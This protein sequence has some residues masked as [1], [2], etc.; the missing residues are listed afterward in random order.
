VDPLA[1]M[2]F[3]YSQ[4]NYTGNNPTN[5]IDP[6]GRWVPGLDDKGNV[7]L[8]A[9]KSDNFMTLV[10][11]YGGDWEMANSVWWSIDSGEEGVTEG[12]SIGGL[13]VNLTK[14]VG[15]IYSEIT[16]AFNAPLSSAL[17]NEDFNCF[18]TS[19]DILRTGEINIEGAIKEGLVGKSNSSQTADALLE[20]NAVPLDDE[21]DAVVG[22]T[23][24]RYQRAG[25]SVPSH[26]ATYMGKDS[27]NNTYVLTK[28]GSFRLDIQKS[29]DFHV[30]SQNWPYGNK[31][32][33]LNGYG[34]IK[35][36]KKD[37]T[38]YYKRK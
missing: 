37:I 31:R 23:L 26:F 11:Y 28:N 36:M 21:N 13:S 7:T 19:L 4:Y 10:D 9:E 29:G 33:D 5:F 34:T 8:T 3:S 22:Q 2:Y 24:I 25:E 18:S 38:G 15:G 20:K 32:I 1:E 16:D 12:E 14:S 6:D 35:G 27:Q 30:K 17:M